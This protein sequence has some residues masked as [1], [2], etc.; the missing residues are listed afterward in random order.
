MGFFAYELGGVLE[1]LPK[2]KS[3]PYPWDMGIGL[4]D[5]VAAFDIEKRAAWVISSGF[6]E[7]EPRQR[8]RRAKSRALEL[9][10]MLGTEPLA[11]LNMEAAGPWRSEIT[12][13]N[14]EACVADA[15]EATYSGDIYQANFSQRF[16]AEISSETRPIEIYRSL[17][18]RSPAPFAAYINAGE[19]MHILSASPERFLEVGPDGAVESRP[20]KGTRPARTNTGGG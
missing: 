5:V 18:A 12:R 11:P 9:A 16:L 19:D 13:E 17:R 7:N 4:Y 8:E 20:I 10:A 14:Y 15:I 3:S 1:T 6:P 2:P